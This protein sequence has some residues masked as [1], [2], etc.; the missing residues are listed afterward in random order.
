MKKINILS[1]TSG[2]GNSFVV[3]DIGRLVNGRLM[4]K[5]NS[6]S[7][8]RIYLSYG[9]NHKNGVVD[10]DAD[11]FRRMANDIKCS[12]YKKLYDTQLGLF[13][14]GCG[15]PEAE[16][17]ISQT[18][19]SLAVLFDIVP[20]EQ[21]KIVI[22]SIFNPDKGLDDMLMY[23]KRFKLFLVRTFLRYI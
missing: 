12:M 19:N 5:V 1:L 6:E 4:F 10:C 8:G 22:E 13:R 2:S 23:T 18:S 21:K 7:S 11:Q 9:F 14:D 17:H 3:M 20:E 15:Q 16:R